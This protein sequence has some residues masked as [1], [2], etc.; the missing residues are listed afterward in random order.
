VDAFDSDVLIY[1]AAKDHDLGRRVRALFPKAPVKGS[2][3]AAGIGSVLLLPEVLTRPTRD[4]A[5]A[6]LAELVVLLS[7]IDLRPL[8]AATAELATV[9]GATYGLRAADAVH[10]ATAV[11]AGADRFMTNNSKDFP[12]SIVEIDVTYPTDLPSRA[13]RR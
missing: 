5:H 4:G 3:P 2:A 10:L 11:A 1:A 8:D 13:A 7:Y 12:R 6:E 9:L